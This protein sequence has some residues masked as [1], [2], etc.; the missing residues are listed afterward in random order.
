MPRDRVN[1]ANVQAANVHFLGSHRRDEA[2]GRGRFHPGSLDRVKTPHHRTITRVN[3]A[4]ISI[5]RAKS[6]PIGPMRA[7][8]LL[9]WQSSMV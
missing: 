4:Q 8:G 6:T 2:K 7:P 5:G 9:H 1:S 3:L